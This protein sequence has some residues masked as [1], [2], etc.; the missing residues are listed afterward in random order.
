MKVLT[1]SKVTRNGIGANGRIS[2]SREALKALGIGIGD[3]VAIVP[4]GDRFLIRKV[5]P[6]DR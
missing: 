5:L 1:S 3:L 2:L 4:E 6:D